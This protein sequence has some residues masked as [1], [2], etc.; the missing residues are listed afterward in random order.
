MTA[1][2]KEKEPEKKEKAPERRETPK[3]PALCTCGV[4]IE[5][6]SSRCPERDCPWRR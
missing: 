3:G 2:P 6:A 4:E 1:N 5:R